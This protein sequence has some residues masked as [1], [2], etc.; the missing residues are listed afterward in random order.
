MERNLREGMG[1]KKA[2]RKTMDEVG[3]ALVAMGLVLVAVFLPTLFLEGISGEFYS[4]FGV[5]IAVATMISVFVSLTLSPAIAAL[6]MKKHE[7][8]HS[9]LATT[10]R[11]SFIPKFF[12]KF[13]Q[14]MDWVS[15]NYGKITSKFIKVRGW[16]LLVY[17]GLILLTVF[18][19]YKVPTGF[20]PQQDQGY[21]IAVIQLPPGASLDRTDKVVQR[22]IDSVMKIDGFKDAVAFTGFDAATFTNSSNAG[23][24]FPVMEDF[25]TRKE[26][27]ITFKDL[28]ASLNKSLG[29]LEDAFV[30]IIPPPSVRGIGNAGGF[31]MMIQD[32]GGLGNDQLLAAGYQMMGAANQDPSLKDV[33]TFF[34]TS[35]P[36]LFFDLDKEK[37]QKLGIPIEEISSA[38]E[39]YLGSAFV[40]DFNLQ[41][42]TF[43]VTAQADGQYR[44]SPEDLT[45]IRVRNKN[46]EMVPLSAIGIALSGLP[47]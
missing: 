28:Q 14:L 42:K 3:G 10:A 18:A 6:V 34:N 40:N 2:A 35:A 7:E 12:G 15:L 22:A 30:V 37:A 38:I 33:F 27:G 41:G 16:V 5:T 44:F 24:I 20:I 9:P 21:F 39:I 25:K 47:R 45:R 11:M 31:K 13:N 1:V 46:N 32:R 36:Q 8:E 23:V 4:Q 26:K 43:R 19:F 17:A 29:G